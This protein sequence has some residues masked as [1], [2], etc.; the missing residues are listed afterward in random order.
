[1]STQKI[2]V[3]DFIVVMFLMNIFVTSQRNEMSM[4]DQTQKTTALS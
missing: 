3:L 1:M 4:A 2:Y